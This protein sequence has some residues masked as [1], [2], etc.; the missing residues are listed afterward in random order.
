MFCFQLLTDV[1]KMATISTDTMSEG[2][3]YLDNAGYSIRW[4]TKDATS[5]GAA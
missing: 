4:E 1:S 2:G 5:A 3:M